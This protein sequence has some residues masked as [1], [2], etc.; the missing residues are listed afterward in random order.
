LLSIHGYAAIRSARQPISALQLAEQRRKFSANE[1]NASRSAALSVAFHRLI[2]RELH[3]NIDP[4][5]FK[6][7]STL[8]VLR[9]YWFVDRKGTPP[10]KNIEPV[11]RKLFL[12]R[13]GLTWINL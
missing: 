2:S 6:E 13:P 1:F 3:S 8:S 12:W 5:V 10:V 11:T 7:V 9:H 4:R